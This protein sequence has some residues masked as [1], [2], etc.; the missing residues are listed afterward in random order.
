MFG[1]ISQSHW[2]FWF[3]LICVS[4]G[5]DDDDEEGE[6]DEDEGEDDLG[7][8]DDDDDDVDEEDDEEEEESNLK[9]LQQSG[10]L[11]VREL[12]CCSFVDTSAN[13]QEFR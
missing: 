3:R 8:D 13:W 4:V 5:E 1:A 11:E 2:Q 12:V 9:L 7:V 10:D 6:E